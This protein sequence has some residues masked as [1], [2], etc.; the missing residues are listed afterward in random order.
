[1]TNAHTKGKQRLEK[2]YNHTQN[3]LSQLPKG[4]T[5]LYKTFTINDFLCNNAVYSGNW[6]G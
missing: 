2:N 5:C 6:K 3:P 4:E 1:M